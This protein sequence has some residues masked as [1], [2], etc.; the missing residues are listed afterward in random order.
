MT[1]R[2]RGFVGLAAAVVVVLAAMAG[3]SVA[4]STRTPAV[5]ES[6]PALLT[7]LFGRAQWAHTAA[8]AGPLANAVTLE[9]VARELQS[10]Q[11]R[12]TGAVVIDRTTEAPA[13]RFCEF[14]VDY[15][16]W[17]DLARLRNDFGWSFVSGGRTHDDVRRASARR[18][19][20][21]IC[22]SRSDLEA[23]GHDRAWG[24]YAYGNNTYSNELQRQV[25]SRC[26]A[27]GRKYG[28]SPNRAPGDDDGFAPTRSINGGK[29]RY[30]SPASVARALNAK[31]G[32]WRVVQFYRFVRGARPR[33]AVTW[34]CTASDAADH[35]TSRDEMY[36]WDD[37]VA[38]LERLSARVAV[39]D[40]AA[41]AEAW[42]VERPPRPSA[43]P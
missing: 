31:P 43:A 20:D 8:C 24:F 28:R 29:N 36:C 25:V 26:F 16:N 18:K 7:I 33:G 34:D 14:G 19:H 32:E 40:P 5:S 9:E 2:R 12:G 35:W 6:E 41:V 27:F 10:R 21:E 22:G 39:V 17:D 11:L 1:A 38:A 42:G 23:R 15:A 37:F 4:E 3:L 30:D 13:P